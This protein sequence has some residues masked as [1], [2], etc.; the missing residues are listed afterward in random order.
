MERIDGFGRVLSQPLIV[1]ILLLGVI[2]IYSKF[3]IFAVS[4]AIL[5]MA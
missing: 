3:V 5:V 4:V 1:I 2:S